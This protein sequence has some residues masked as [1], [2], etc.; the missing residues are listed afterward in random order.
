M[1]TLSEDLIINI[2]DYVNFSTVLVM[3]KTCKDI[4][5]IISEYYYHM[6]RVYL[7]IENWNPM[8]NKM[9]DDFP[10]IPQVYLNK[11]HILNLSNKKN[12]E[13]KDITFLLFKLNNV[14]S[15]ILCYNAF[16]YFEEFFNHKVRSILVKIYQ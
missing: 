2:L 5:K 16:K 12:I 3:G 14:Y 8:E 9:R 10:E 13:S 1:N 7:F 4:N 6:N 11:I 15:V